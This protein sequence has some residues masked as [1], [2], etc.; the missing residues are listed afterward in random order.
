MT[1]TDKTTSR[2]D[3]LKFTAT[4]APAAA[5]ASVLGATEAEAVESSLDKGLQD[6][7]HIRSYYDSAR[8]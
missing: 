7:A 3:F 8:F 4:A 5:A 6:T 1:K 2:R